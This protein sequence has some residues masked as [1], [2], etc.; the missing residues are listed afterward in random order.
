MFLRALSK[1]RTEN[2]QHVEMGKVGNEQVGGIWHLLLLLL[3]C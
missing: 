1:Q 2:Q 3:D